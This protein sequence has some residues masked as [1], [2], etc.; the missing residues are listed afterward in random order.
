MGRTSTAKRSIKFTQFTPGLGPRLFSRTEGATVADLLREAGE[1]ITGV[2]VLTD[3]KPIEEVTA[4]KSGMIVCL[5]PTPPTSSG[6]RSWRD[7]VGT[8][9][10]TPE[11]Q[12]MIAAGRAIREADDN[13]KPR[14]R[15][16]PR[17]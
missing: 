11:F 14:P 13:A 15:P 2:S 6:K 1:P 16:C 12:E 3:G 7:S 5:A 8:V 10:D 9:Q 4:L 17:I